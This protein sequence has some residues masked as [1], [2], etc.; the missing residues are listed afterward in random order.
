MERTATGT[1]GRVLVVEDEAL[2]AEEIKERLTR[3]DFHV[4]G[5]EAY[6]ER[7]LERI[8]EL[9]P[10]LVMMDIRLKGA[11]D[12]IEVARR[13]RAEHDLPVV[14]LT[15]HSDEATL[16]RAKDTAPL[17]Y[18]LKP[19]Q[20]RELQIAVEMALHRH[21]LE[22][23]L[24]ESE[25][26]HAATLTSIGDGVVATGP[27]GR[28]TMLN[29]V[30][31]ELTGWSSSQARDR[32]ADEVFVVMDQDTQ[33]RLPDPIDTALRTGQIM[34]LGDRAAI[35]SRTGEL[36]PIDDS[37]APIRDASGR[38]LGAVVVFRDARDRRRAEAAVREAEQQ[39][40]QSQKMESIGRMAASV[41]HDFNNILTVVASCCELLRRRGDLHAD[42]DQLVQE[43]AKAAERANTFTRQLLAVGRRHPVDPRNLDLNGLLVAL[44]P[45]L[46]RLLRRGIDLRLDLDPSLGELTAD[47]G[48]IEQ[49]MLNLVG[50][51]D[52]AMPNGGRLTIATARVDSPPHVQHQHGPWVQLTVSDTGVGMD[53]ATRLRVFEPFFST[54]QRGRGSG[55]GLATVH[56]LV[57]Q[58]GGLIQVD[59]TPGAGTSFR[60]YLPGATP[61]RSDPAAAAT[62]T[63]KLP[64]APP[65]PPAAPGGDECLLVVEAD[66]ML[67]KV[68]VRTLTRLGYQVMAAGSGAEAH[69]MLA[70]PGGEV[71]LLVTNPAFAAIA[72]GRP[73]LPVLV[74]A[75]CGEQEQST[76]AGVEGRISWLQKPF[77]PDDLARAVRA[78]LDLTRS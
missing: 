77:H 5:I 78:A 72:A 71:A 56:G 73:G 13:M 43:I 47:P 1:R 65:G 51:A 7:A 15:A 46:R 62:P 75:C 9:R 27:D 21:G 20:E 74:L 54:K 63:G 64:D 50:N 28:V 8:D 16:Q 52:D 42:A 6:G 31:E 30:A 3:L 70:E 22:R 18:V 2:I 17:G 59:S 29:P 39:V 67:C 11:M 68:V 25:L 53:E 41:A 19:L 60:I 4:V 33:S 40:R 57:T 26:R 45:T 34:R 24:R 44:Q 12:G 76:P 35:V 66:A 58:A 48:H 32:A 10:D 36:I 14:Y 61:P 38:V 23:R 49:I 55:M 37:V 69:R